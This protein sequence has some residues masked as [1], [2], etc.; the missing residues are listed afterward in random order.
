MSRAAYHEA[1]HAVAW[2]V[3]IGDVGGIEIR[4]DAP[5]VAFY[6]ASVKSTPHAYREVN[7]V[8][9]LAGGIAQSLWSEESLDSVY[10]T[11]GASD[12]RR[13]F[14]LCFEMQSNIV[15]DWMRCKGIATDLV[16][17]NWHLINRLANALHDRPI[18]DER[19]TLSA[20]EVR[21]VLASA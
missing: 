21:D 1:G 8:V 4:Y 13:F 17:D 19:S 5:S 12:V 2:W 3:L 20:D 15:E 11:D 7:Q 9:Y 6:P 14:R 10:R 18:V 16:R